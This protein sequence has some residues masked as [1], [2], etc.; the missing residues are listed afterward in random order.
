MLEAIRLEAAAWALRRQA[1][2]LDAV[3]GRLRSRIDQSVN[4]GRWQGPSARKEW[5][6]ML[7]RY[8]R[9][10]KASGDMR[11]LASRF[12][13]RAQQLRDEERRKAAALLH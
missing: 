10:R 6:D 8:A 3:V 11:D 13:R 9:M 7:D 1:D 5:Q 4:G 2:Q 12:Q